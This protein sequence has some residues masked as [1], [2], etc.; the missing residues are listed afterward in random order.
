MKLH[1]KRAITIWLLSALVLLT[2]LSNIAAQTAGQEK[3]RAQVMIL[4]VYH[5]DNPNQDYVKTNVDDHLSQ[6]RQEQ[7]AEVSRL[8]AKFKPTKI[9]LE[10][11]EGPSAI[12]RNYEAYLKGEY[13]LKA[14]ER[15]QIGL[16]LAKQMGHK[17]VY[18]ADHKLDMDFGGVMQ[19]A[20]ESG[21]R[22]FL[23]LFQSVMGEIEAFE[24]RKARMTV[25]DILIEMNGQ[26]Q[27]A[28]ARDLYIQMARV[29]NGDKFIGADVLAGWYQRNFRIFS[30][31]A[32][33]IESVE[34]RVLIIFGAGHSPILREL[35]QSSPD[36]QLV[37]PNDYLKKQ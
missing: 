27:I 19:A 23:E 17:R 33:V 14:D 11:V 30:I 21:N 34:D 7:I 2:S 32:P 28:K 18:A 31:F 5:M 15:D 29:R 16:R 20:Q 10:A 24:K 6:K 8:L 1:L 36:L 4:G 37:E 22:A 26:A 25:G 12:H 9:V 3:K 35:V 13:T